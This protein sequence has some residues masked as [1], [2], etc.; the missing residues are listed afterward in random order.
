ML[1]KCKST[2]FLMEAG[3]LCFVE[4]LPFVSFR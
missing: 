2:R 1:T 3:A 4:L